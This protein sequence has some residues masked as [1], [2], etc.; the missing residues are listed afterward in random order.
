MFMLVGRRV[1]LIQSCNFVFLNSCWSSK[2]RVVLNCGRIVMLV[3][4][5]VLLRIVFCTSITYFQDCILF[6][7]ENP[8]KTTSLSHCWNS[9]TNYVH[10]ILFKVQMGLYRCCCLIVAILDID[11]LFSCVTFFTKG[12]YFSLI[13]CLVVAISNIHLQ[14]SFVTF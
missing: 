6:R 4:V 3:S 14:Y 13:A 5:A 11:F 10:S 7:I 2:S 8:P 9:G 12:I 1:V